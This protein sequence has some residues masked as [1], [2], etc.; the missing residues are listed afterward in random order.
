MC[1]SPA[2]HGDYV[3]CSVTLR[4]LAVF[5]IASCAAMCV[6][7]LLQHRNVLDQH[8]AWFEIAE[9]ALLLVAYATAAL[10]FPAICRRLPVAACRYGMTVGCITGAIELVNLAVETWL[11][12]FNGAAVSLGFMLSVFLL[13]GVA[14]ERSAKA[15][16]S[17]RG[18]IGAALASAA[19]CMLIA[20]SAGLLLEFFIAPPDVA[21]VAQWTEF[22]RS[23]W[24]D[25]RAFAVINTIDSA[26]THLMVAPFVAVVF[27]FAGSLLSKRKIR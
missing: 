2:I 22:H 24:T 9:L 21:A 15:G 6:L 1:N 14:A 11:P 5:L 10:L 26:S 17:T 25:V 27:G 4:I 8:G 13:W 16:A 19:L 7:A 20:V 12:S 23:G 3:S 18:A